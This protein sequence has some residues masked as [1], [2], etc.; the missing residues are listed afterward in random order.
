MGYID[1]HI[2]TTAS[3]GTH[4]PDELISEIL[5]KGITHFSVTDHDSI[6]HIKTLIRLAKEN[7]LKF[8]P[9]CEISVMYENQ[10]LHILTY[11]I[12]L[13]DQALQAILAENILIRE[14]HNNALIQYACTK[15]SLISFIDYQKYE[16]DRARGG[17]KSINYLVERGVIKDLGEFFDLIKDFG[18][19]L[20]FK[21]HYEMLPRLKE[22]G[23]PLVLAHPPAY[24]KG[25]RLSESWL[26]E[27]RMLG[28][29]GIECYSPYFKH[30]EDSDYYIDYC[31]K[32]HM[33]ITCGSD[34]HG[35]FIKTRHLATPSK[36]PED[37]MIKGFDFL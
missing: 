29:T 7:N 4:E 22:L 31:M 3:D 24:F 15:T 21:P 27:L 37:L 10:E 13:N 35:R 32:H 25:A 19:P 16:D 11:G 9:G 20:T 33:Q 12:D 17:W 5:A 34:Y 14:V 6:D 30:P 26:D 28:I 23:Y 2:H 36:R 8:L 1:L 18:T